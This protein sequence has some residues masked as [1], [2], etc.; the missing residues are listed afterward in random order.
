[1]AVTNFN[2]STKTFRELMGNGLVYTVP[3]FQRDYSWTEVEWD[4]LWQ[5]ILLTVVPD[6]EQ[7]HYMGYLVLQSNDDKNYNIIA[8]Q[9]R[10][11]TLSLI[12]L[13]VLNN[14]QNLI[15]KNIDE[16]NNNL[17]ANA[18]RGTYIGYLDPV[19]LVSKS[20]LK[21]NRHND[22]F[23]K[24]YIV[25]LVKLPHRKLKTSEQL[26]R[27]AFEWFDKK[28]DKRFEKNP[29]GAEL[30]R[31]LDI[32]ADCLF[33][34]L[35]YVKDE[36][37]AFTVF[38]TLNARGVRLS[39]TDLLKNYLFSVVDSSG[40]HENEISSLEDLWEIIVD[41]LGSES[42]PDFLRV[43]WNSYN[44]LTRHSE[45]FK[46]IRK[47]IKDKADVFT[48]IRRMDNKSDIY[49]ALSDANNSLWTKEQ[50]K[51]I[52]QLKM[53]NV[54]QPYSMLLA[55]LEAL[56]ED[57]F[58]RILRACTIASF[59]YNVIGTLSPNEQERVYNAIAEKISKGQLINAK[60]I[61][62]SLRSIYPS[63]EQFLTAFTEKEF[64]ITRN[65]KVVRYILFEIE[66][67]VSGKDYDQNS[68]KYNVEHILP[69]NP[70]DNW[71]EFTDE[72]V[73]NYLYRIGN[74]TLWTIGSNRDIGNK[75]YQQKRTFYE[76]SEFEITKGIAL[77][78]KEWTP[79]RIVSRQK[80]LAQQATAVWRISELSKEK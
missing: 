26:L 76:Q 63:D 68:D 18:L 60:D 36:L 51:Y 79:D 56:N 47:N 42:V 4:E 39:A 66:K 38:E 58:T 8:G 52:S 35:I 80:R 29:D 19:T 75:S 77:D 69:K 78:N 46:T 27:K 34:T 53:F 23:Y 72:Q 37:N 31:F 57:D 30:A 55:A 22:T 43:F 14:L 13:A 40:S 21:L 11:T 3:R 2:T 62:H 45:L 9:Q 49:I 15:K 74:M 5:D 48:L 41:K 16:D 25:P 50:S 59:R 1:M 67:H 32:L 33:F 44:P 10:I 71:Q 73:E 70:E 61:I 54:K 64:R 20:K 6:G 28:I 24:T 12:V 17:R 7:N 65:L